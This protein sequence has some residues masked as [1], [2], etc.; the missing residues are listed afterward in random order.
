[1]YA[2]RDRFHCLAKR[3]TRGCLQD[4]FAGHDFVG[5]PVATRKQFN[6]THVETSPGHMQHA[7]KPAD[8]VNNLAKLVIKKLDPEYRPV[9]HGWLHPGSRTRRKSAGKNGKGGQTYFC[10]CIQQDCN[11]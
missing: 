4:T 1:M 10:H 5:V 8:C 6:A 3:V 2:W 9:F 11:R 7:Y